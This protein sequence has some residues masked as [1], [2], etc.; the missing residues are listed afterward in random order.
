MP[1]RS[2]CVIRQASTLHALPVELQDEFDRL[3]RRKRRTPA[4]EHRLDELWDLAI[5]LHD[6]QWEEAP[7]RIPDN[8]LGLYAEQI[9][10]RMRQARQDTNVL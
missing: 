10:E 2:L 7:P 4:V 9:A 8:D 5:Q 1:V 3:D 6:R